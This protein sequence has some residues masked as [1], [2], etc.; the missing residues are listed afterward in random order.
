MDQTIQYPDLLDANDQESIILKATI[1]A[2]YLTLDEI[3]DRRH[4]VTEA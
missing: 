3:L 4:G 1:I 2:K